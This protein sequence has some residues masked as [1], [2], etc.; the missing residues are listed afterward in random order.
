M[1]KATLVYFDGI[2]KHDGISS[3][4]FRV[5]DNRKINTI[6]VE[7]FENGIATIDSIGVYCSSDLAE[8][9]SGCFDD[10]SNFEAEVLNV[11]NC[12]NTRLNGIKFMFNGVIILITRDNSNEDF[13]NIECYFD[14]SA[15]Y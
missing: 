12:K 1:A 14:L 10:E 6:L 15:D 3:R 2:C 13:V 8:V 4:A 7:S 11:F 9:V 5:I